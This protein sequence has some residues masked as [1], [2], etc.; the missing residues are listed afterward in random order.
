MPI[1]TRALR[2]L[3]PPWFKLWVSRLQDKHANQYTTADYTTQQLSVHQVTTYM[4]YTMWYN[5][6]SHWQRSSQTTT[7]PNS[8]EL[9]DAIRG[10]PA[11]PMLPNKSQSTS[12]DDSLYLT[13]SS[14]FDLSSVRIR[15]I[16]LYRHIRWLS[17][18]T[19]SELRARGCRAQSG[20]KMA[21]YYLQR[22]SLILK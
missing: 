5:V 19:Y 22:F 11:S 4:W 6:R 1:L 20:S 15:N 13:V 9:M 16:C 14:C 8:T 10:C 2:D 3:L 12:W 17:T 7:Q 21:S 18:I